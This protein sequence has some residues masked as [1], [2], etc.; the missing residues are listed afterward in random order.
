MRKLSTSFLFLQLAGRLL[1]AYGLLLYLLPQCSSGLHRRR[2][3]LI[4]ENEMFWQCFCAPCL[5]S[6]FI[7]PQCCFSQNITVWKCK[8]NWQSLELTQNTEHTPVSNI[9]KPDVQQNQRSDMSHTSLYS[10]HS[11]TST[12]NCQ[13]SQRSFQIIESS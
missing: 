4:P 7:P 8:V 2:A 10:S 13:N 1:T 9:L 3:K 11:N 6:V 5:C 12:H